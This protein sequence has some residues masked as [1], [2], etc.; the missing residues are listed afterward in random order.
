MWNALLRRAA[1]GLAILLLIAPVAR[2]TE[3]VTGT[4]A[5]R[6]NLMAERGAVVVGRLADAQ[7]V[8][9]GKTV[10]GTGTLE[11]ERSLTGGLPPTVTLR[12]SNEVGLVCPRVDHQR[13]VGRRAVWILGIPDGAWT[14]RNGDVTVLDR[15]GSDALVMQLAPV[16]SPSAVVRQVLDIAYAGLASDIP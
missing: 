16:A 1:A 15:R 7:L 9:R 11:V 10:E 6:L 4:L 3:V 2:S 12:W 13:L 14:A 8:L 5:D